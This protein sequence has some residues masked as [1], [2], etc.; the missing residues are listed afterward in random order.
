MLKIVS[1]LGM[2]VTAAG[3]STSQAA[4]VTLDTPDGSMLGGQPVDASVMITTG[5]GTVDVVL[6]NL[7]AN[8][9]SVIQNLS[10]LEISFDN[11]VGAASLTLSSGQEVTVAGDQSFTLGAIV[12]TGWALSSPGS[13]KLY[14]NVLG[15]LIGPAHTIIGPPGGPTYSAAGGAIAGNM[16][17]N[18]FL[19]ETASFSISAPGVTAD[20]LVTEVVFSFGTVPGETITVPEPVGLTLGGLG[21]GLVGLVRRRRS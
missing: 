20:T 17:H 15:T 13:N 2:L 3:V 7:Q 4:V 10:D 1:V 16:P 9:I 5:A 6:T 21:L 19:S 8:P 12:D 11:D 18:P 14:L